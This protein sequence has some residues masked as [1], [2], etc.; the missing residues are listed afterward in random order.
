MDVLVITRAVLIYSA[1]KCACKQDA[2]SVGTARILPYLNE[3][4]NSLDH[5]VPV[6]QGECNPTPTEVVRVKRKWE[7][8]VHDST[9]V[10]VLWVDHFSHFPFRGELKFFIFEFESVRQCFVGEVH[11]VV[12]QVGPVRFQV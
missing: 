9:L 5:F 7:Y 11:K 4:S 8:V 10:D 2:V 12:E 6:S 1:L 3:F